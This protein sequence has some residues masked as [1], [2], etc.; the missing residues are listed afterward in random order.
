MA[1][2][3]VELYYKGKPINP[4]RDLPT[5][6]Y[7]EAQAE[8]LTSSDK[9]WVRK[10]GDG[11]VITADEVPYDSN[12]SVGDML[13]MKSGTF[14]ASSGV[15]IGSRNNWYKEGKM[16]FIS[17]VLIINSNIAD[18]GT[19]VTT[20]GLNLISSVYIMGRKDADWT[21]VNL[22]TNGNDIITEPSIASGTI[23]RIGVAVPTL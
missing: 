4:N 13:D 21:M 2:E 19:L 10:D 23:L 9:L 22:T 20:T 16:A 15:S 8:G 18:G 12:N 17:L 7:A 5:R 1:N 6:T 14:T 11:T 3:T